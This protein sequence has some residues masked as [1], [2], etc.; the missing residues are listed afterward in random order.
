MEPL[1]SPWVFYWISVVDHV[2]TAVT[3]AMIVGSLV[4]FLAVLLHF[5]GC[6]WS[7]RGKVFLHRLAKESLCVA[8]FSALV[9]PF[10][11]NRTTCLE[12]L[13][14]SK[15]TPDNLDVLKGASDEVRQA[16]KQD[17]LDLIE[18]IKEE[19]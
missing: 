11:P 3:C 17:V 14:A 5:I 13:V 9:Y 16:V 18:T 6:E 10:V 19:K 15:V 2:Q 1:V 7:E 8:L 4:G 12:M